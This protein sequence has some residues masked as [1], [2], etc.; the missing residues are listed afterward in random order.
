MASS[1][2]LGLASESISP[3]P[4]GAPRFVAESDANGHADRTWGC[5]LA[6]NAAHG[7]VG[8]IRVTSRQP[9]AGRNL[10]NGY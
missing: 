4:T 9:R 8:E 7:D 6:L 1:R 5:F 10:T 3:S 2:T